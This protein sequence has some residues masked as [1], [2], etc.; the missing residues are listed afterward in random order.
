MG[1]PV[2]LYLEDDG[3]RDARTAETH[4]E[5]AANHQRS[6]AQTLNS[7]TLHNRGKMIEKKET[8]ETFYPLIIH[9]S[10]VLYVGCENMSKTSSIDTVQLCFFPHFLISLLMTH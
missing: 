2:K 4:E 7:E 10:K 3:H 9:F 1:H 6:S 8:G 5:E